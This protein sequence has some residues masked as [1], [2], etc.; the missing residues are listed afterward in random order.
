M[1]DTPQRSSDEIIA[2]ILDDFRHAGEANDPW[3]L[4]PVGIAF[5][6]IF[7][8]LLMAGILGLAFF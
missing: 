5:Y 2:Q 8:P 7:V 3:W 6:L 1:S 4:I